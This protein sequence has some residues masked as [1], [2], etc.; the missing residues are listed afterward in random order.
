[1]G[2]LSRI[3]GKDLDAGRHSINEHAPL[4]PTQADIPRPTN[5]GDYHSVRSIP[6]LDRPRYFSEAEANA[7]QELAKKK[8]AG[9]K[10]TEKALAA[11]ESIEASDTKVHELYYQYRGKVAEL[12]LK[13]LGANA[14]YASK[15]HGLR[16]GYAGLQAKIRKAETGANQ[17]IQKLRAS[18][19]GG[20]SDD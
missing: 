18:L 4:A 19:Y 3:I 1:M 10:H 9:A 5:P 2:F 16:P 11:M 13:K 8:A 14:S 6:Y 17:R 7:L 12:E 20:N 15:L